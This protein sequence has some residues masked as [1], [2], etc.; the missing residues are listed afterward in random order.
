[1]VESYWG[2]PFPIGNWYFRSKVLLHVRTCLTFPYWEL[3][4]EWVIE[5]NVFVIVCL[6]TFPYWELI[7][8]ATL[9]HF[10]FW[11]LA[12]LSLLGIDTQDIIR[13]NQY[14]RSSYLSLLGIDTNK[15]S[16]EPDLSKQTTYLSLLGID[17]R[18]SHMKDDISVFL[19]PFPI[20]NWYWLL[21]FHVT[22]FSSDAY[23]SLL[24]I[25]TFQC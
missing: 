19:L 21:E 8:I 13:K 6:L 9:D 4:P 22:I 20:G 24:G 7:R 11:F 16:I 25:D 14:K 3:I 18:Y 17:T 12:Y 1:M 5:K 2:L 15:L 10:Y 23:L